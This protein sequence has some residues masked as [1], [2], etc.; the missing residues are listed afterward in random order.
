MG[1]HRNALF[2]RLYLRS[3][4][5]SFQS[6]GNSG[7]RLFDVTVADTKI[8]NIDLV[9]LVGKNTPYATTLTVSTTGPTLTIFME[10]S[11]DKAKISAIEINAVAIGSPVSV[12]FAMPAPAKAPVQPPL[13]TKCP[14]PK[15][16]DHCV[17]MQCEFHDSDAAL[18]YCTFALPL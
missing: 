5:S 9:V 12:P 13:P 10:A 4:L 16:R 7:A 6:W 1:H 18:V 15:V 8:A 11:K 3:L 17:C 2:V 14:L